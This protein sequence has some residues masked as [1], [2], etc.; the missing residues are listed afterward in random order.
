MFVNLCCRGGFLRGGDA[1]QT[2]GCQSGSAERQRAPAAELLAKRHRQSI[3]S[4]CIHWGVLIHL[5]SGRVASCD[6]EKEP[7]FLLG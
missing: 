7:G 6:S 1:G 5:A 2:S 4:V 3:E